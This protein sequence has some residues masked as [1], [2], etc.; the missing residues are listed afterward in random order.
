[1]HMLINGDF[2]ELTNE[3]KV[4]LMKSYENN[5][6]MI[7]LVNDMLAADRIES[8]RTKVERIKI[9]LR[10][11]VE[12]VLFEL[13]SN[14][15]RQ[16]VKIDFEK[17]DV[18]EAFV[19]V[20]ASK[21]RAVLQNVLENAIKYTRPGGT[22]TMR[23]E[24]REKDFLAIVKDNGIGIPVAQQ[25]QIFSRFFRASNAVKVETS[26]SGL[27]LYM[28][29]KIIELHGGKCWFESEENKGTTF[30]FTLPIYNS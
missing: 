5:E 18:T 8:G 3:Q 27:G 21:M 24:K 10:D 4:F 30:Y 14:A 17:N 29:K 19:L 26:G 1:M 9:N 22:V 15:T 23:I 20:D 13:V 25:S 11:L 7:G 16:K 2:G 12:N 28:V 6:R